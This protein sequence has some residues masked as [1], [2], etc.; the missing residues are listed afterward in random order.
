MQSTGQALDEFGVGLQLQDFFNR[1][2]GVL[3]QGGQVGESEGE[4]EG[5]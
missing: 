4:G 1:D 5:A 3:K 2:R